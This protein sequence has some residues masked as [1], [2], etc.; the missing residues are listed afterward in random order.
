MS[1]NLMKRRTVAGKFIFPET[2]FPDLEQCTAAALA[3]ADDYVMADEHGTVDYRI[4][5]VRAN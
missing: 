4:D 1:Y 3:D 2:A 5:G